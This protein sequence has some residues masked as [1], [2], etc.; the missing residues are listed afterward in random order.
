MDFEK[1]CGALLMGRSGPVLDIALDGL[2]AGLTESPCVSPLPSSPFPGL[3]SLLN[4]RNVP[5]GMGGV[6]AFGSYKIVLPCRNL[7]VVR[8]FGSYLSRA[9]DMVMWAAEDAANS[10]SPRQAAACRTNWASWRKIL[11]ILKVCS[12]FFLFL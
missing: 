6:G 10:G 3:S 11:S 2:A 5:R 9:E 12:R 1:V 7:S 8:S 4:E